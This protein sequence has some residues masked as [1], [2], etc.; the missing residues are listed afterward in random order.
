[1]ISTLKMME[2]T[3]KV[4]LKELPT[5]DEIMRSIAAELDQE[6]D[7]LTTPGMEQIFIIIR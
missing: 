5:E 2:V 3:Q 1:M 7:N 4:D 6:V